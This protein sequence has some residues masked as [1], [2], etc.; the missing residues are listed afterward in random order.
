MRTRSSASG[1]YGRFLPSGQRAPIVTVES[2]IRRT[3]SASAA[4]PSFSAF[5]DRR[6]PSTAPTPT[7]PAAGAAGSTTIPPVSG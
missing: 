6:A 7:G 4:P 3:R 2:S 5:S 1:P